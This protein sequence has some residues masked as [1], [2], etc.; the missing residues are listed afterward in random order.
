MPV[1]QTTVSSWIEHPSLRWLSMKSK[2]FFCCLSSFEANRNSYN[3]FLFLLPYGHYL[4][5]EESIIQYLRV[6][7]SIIYWYEVWY[8]HHIIQTNWFLL[9]LIYLSG[10]YSL[11][12]GITRHIKTIAR[13]QENTILGH[14]TTFNI[15]SF[16]FCVVA[17]ISND[18]MSAWIS[19]HNAPCVLA[20]R[21]VCVAH[22]GWPMK[23]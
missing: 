2:I 18:T 7:K 20:V 4:R 13:P 14:D 10:L 3:S 9:A 8:Q 22:K 23:D 16:F 17:R 5:A 1:H 11:S 15:V 6:E 21:V 12:N 19:Y